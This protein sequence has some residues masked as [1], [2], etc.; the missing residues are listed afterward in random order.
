MSGRSL[1]PATAPVC[2]L[3]LT[4]VSAMAGQAQAEA[5]DWAVEADPAARMTP[6]SG[7]AGV[8]ERDRKRQDMYARWTLPRN[9]TRRG[10]W[11]AL[12]RPWPWPWG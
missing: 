12:R 3:G 4:I 11:P 8:S 1:L 5:A 9:I 10:G 7:L 6:L 2:L